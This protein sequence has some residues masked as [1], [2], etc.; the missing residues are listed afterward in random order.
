[1]KNW[2][3]IIKP[4]KTLKYL[5]FFEAIF[6]PACHACMM[7]NDM[8]C[9][10]LYRNGNTSPRM[11]TENVRLEVGFQSSRPSDNGRTTVSQ[12]TV[13]RSFN[14][15]DR[16]YD[17]ALLRLSSALDF[18]DQLRPVCLPGSSTDVFSNLTRCVV[19]GLAYTPLSGGPSLSMS[20][21]CHLQSV[22]LQ[23]RF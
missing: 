8:F 10:G 7:I 23:G 14:G 1:M 6:Q 17:I 20:C 19:T 3:K 11:S 4:K 2:T 12:V 13:H 21:D 22:S 5:D 18:G 16:S 15:T 9:L